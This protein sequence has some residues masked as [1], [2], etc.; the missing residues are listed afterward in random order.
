M[1]YSTSGHTDSIDSE[2]HN[3]D[4]SLRRAKAVREFLIER[5]VQPN[6]LTAVG[7]GASRPIAD[8]ATELGRQQN[9]RIE[10]VVRQDASFILEPKEHT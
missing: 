3:R 5:G 6:I 7:Y 2:E 10:F 1:S 9:R 8:N 4:L